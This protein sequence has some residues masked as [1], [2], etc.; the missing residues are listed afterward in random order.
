M[1][2]R[3]KARPTWVGIPAR[4]AAVSAFALGLLLSSPASSQQAGAMNFRSFCGAV[5]YKVL[6]NHPTRDEIL[7]RYQ[8]M[9]YNAAGV[10][11]EDRLEVA[12][13]KTKAFMDA[14]AAFLT[15][16]TLNFHPRNGNIYK[17][18]VARQ[19]DGFINDALDNWRV[20]LN[21]IDATDGKTVL[22]YIADRRAMAGPT[23]ARTLN[24]YYARFRAAGARHARELQ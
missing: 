13:Q 3:L 6:E 1:K 14:N 18:A 16:N 19:A 10:L 17:L 7:Y 15:C 21:Q 24:R 22:D 20:D 23:Y 2:Q 5:E 4:L 12:Y 11:P 9:V 8:T